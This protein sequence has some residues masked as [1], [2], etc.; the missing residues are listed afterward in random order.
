MLVAPVQLPYYSHDFHGRDADLQCEDCAVSA[1]GY[2]LASPVV[3]RATHDHTLGI[4]LAVTKLLERKFSRIGL[5]CSHAM[6][7]QV[8]GRWMAGFLL[9]QQLIQAAHQ[10]PPLVLDDFNNVKA[11]DQWFDKHRPEA[12]IAAETQELK[13]HLDRRG[14]SVP[15]DISV[16]HLDAS[17]SDPAYAG[18]DQRRKEIGAAAFDLLLGQIHRHERGIPIQRKTVMLEGTWVEGNSIR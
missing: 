7:V 6:H 2:S 10:I 5:V 12:L 14:I 15:K 13:L 8:E 4:E 16:V 3:N 18:I 17:A 1:I 9:A 11:F